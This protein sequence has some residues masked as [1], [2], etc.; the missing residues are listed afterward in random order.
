MSSE[1]TVNNTI[2]REHILDNG[3]ELEINI[4]NINTSNHSKR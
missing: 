2:D 3:G 4:E 1:I